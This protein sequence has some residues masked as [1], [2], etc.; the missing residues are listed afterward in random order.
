[1]N[2]K[3]LREERNWTQSELAAKMDVDIRTIQK[4]EKPGAGIAKKNLRLLEVIF[5]NNT[6]LGVESAI[7]NPDEPKMPRDQMD[8]ILMGMSELS[9]EEREVA[10]RKEV[11]RLRHL[12]ER[13]AI[14]GKS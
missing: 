8:A 14:V 3:E 1:M 7:F 10:L 11:L 12:I 4:W 5:R 6:T 2:I 9:L 13:M